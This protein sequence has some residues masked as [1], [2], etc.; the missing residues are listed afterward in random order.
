M[1]LIIF[2]K[3][4]LVLGCASLLFFV[5]YPESTVMLLLKLLAGSAVLSVVVSIVYP[6][7]RGV[8]TGDTVSVVS[9]TGV[10]LLLGRL[11]RAMEQGRKN[12]KIK[13]RL[14]NGNEVIGV[15]ETY[16][17]LITPPR[18]RLIYEERLVE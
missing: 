6:D 8:K 7:V 14:D 3:L 11:G 12:N 16:D 15:V 2:A 18:I 1:R 10:S 17:G 5:F 4:M 9:G 13:V